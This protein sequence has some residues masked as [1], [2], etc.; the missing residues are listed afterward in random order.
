MRLRF[1]SSEQRGIKPSFL[2]LNQRGSICL[3]L[4]NGIKWSL[5]NLLALRRNIKAIYYHHHHHH[6]HQISRTARISQ[7]LSQYLNL[8]SF[9]PGRSSKLHVSSCRLT[10]TSSKLFSFKLISPI[11]STVFYKYTKLYIYIYMCVCVCVCV[12]LILLLYGNLDVFFA[13]KNSTII[14]NT[15]S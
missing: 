3:G 13:Y 15:S 4:I 7:S 5:I 10:K 8:S 2:L 1:W 9:A 12:C 11:L 14:I 6:H